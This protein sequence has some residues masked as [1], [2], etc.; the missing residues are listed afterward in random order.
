M[1]PSARRSQDTDPP[2]SPWGSGLSRTGISRLSEWIHHPK[3]ARNFPSP[4][5][6]LSAPGTSRKSLV[7]ME[8]RYPPRNTQTFGHIERQVTGVLQDAEPTRKL[9]LSLEYICNS[10]LVLLER[11]T[12]MV[13]R[14]AEEC[15]AFGPIPMVP[16]LINFAG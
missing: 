3:M 2:G 4:S 5:E 1:I 12:P 10:R 8:L 14:S 11:R 16:P 13:L 9:H 6:L 7:T 15:P